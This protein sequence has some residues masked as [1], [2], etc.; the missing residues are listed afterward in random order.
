MPVFLLQDVGA[1]LAQQDFPGA[2]PAGVYLHGPGRSAI[3]DSPV[4]AI[5]PALGRRRALLVDLLG[6]GFSERPPAFDYSSEG[7]ALAVAALLFDRG[8]AAV[9]VGAAG[10]RP[11]AT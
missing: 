5:V 2:G 6:H 1:I 9:G 3:A 7:H 8:L 11:R 10:A 4:I